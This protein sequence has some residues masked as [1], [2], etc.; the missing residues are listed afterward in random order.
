MLASPVFILQKES[1]SNDF[2]NAICS[3]TELRYSFDF[4]NQNTY[5]VKASLSTT[6]MEKQD[7]FVMHRIIMVTHQ[8]FYKHT[9]RKKFLSTKRYLRKINPSFCCLWLVLHKSKPQGTVFSRITENKS[10]RLIQNAFGWYIHFQVATLASANC[11]C[12]AWHCMRA[13]L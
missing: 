9:V 12:R 1:A 2:D 7:L 4:L 5:S 10:A 6:A 8:R 11:G 3:K 13:R